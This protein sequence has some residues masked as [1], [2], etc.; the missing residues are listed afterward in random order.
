MWAEW[1]DGMDDKSIHQ[2]DAGLSRQDT[3]CST[4]IQGIGQ[5]T[6]MLAHALSAAAAAVAATGV[7]PISPDHINNDIEGVRRPRN[8]KVIFNRWN[9]NNTNIILPKMSY[10]KETDNPSP[11]TVG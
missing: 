9:Y 4:V 8:R 11:S 7:V 10:D 5:I 3:N 1:Q 6:S 2:V